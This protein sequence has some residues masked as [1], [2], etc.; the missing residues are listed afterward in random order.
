VDRRG[1]NLALVS[2]ETC[3]YPITQNRTDGDRPYNFMEILGPSRNRS[4]DIT[5]ENSALSSLFKRSATLI[6]VPTATVPSVAYE[7]A[8][9]GSTIHAV[10]STAYRIVAGAFGAVWSVGSYVSAPLRSETEATPSTDRGP[11]RRGGIRLSATT[12]VIPASPATPANPATTTD[13][14]RCDNVRTLH[15]RR[16]D[17]T[18]DRRYYNGNQV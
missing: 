17:R 5:D 11:P 4:L 18:E 3:T 13:S 15:D 2:S 7:T 8:T 9:S 16:D 10:I 12:P 1:E 14:S 6:L